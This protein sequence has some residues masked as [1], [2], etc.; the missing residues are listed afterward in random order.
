MNAINHNKREG[1]SWRNEY[2]T[3]FNNKYKSSQEIEN[4]GYSIDSFCNIVKL[5][6]TEATLLKGCGLKEEL[7]EEAIKL[8]KNISSNLEIQKEEINL[9][10]EI[11]PE[12]AQNFINNVYENYQKGGAF[13]NIINYYNTISVR[14]RNTH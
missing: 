6:K 4:V 8:L 10:A 11:D 14:K 13:K 9:T 2:S 1:K 7:A 5:L 3:Y 12:K